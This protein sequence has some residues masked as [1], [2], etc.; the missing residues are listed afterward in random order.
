MTAL[1]RR[2]AL[3]TLALAACT[4]LVHAQKL[5]KSQTP[6]EIT[7]TTDLKDFLKQRDSLQLQRHDG[8]LTYKSDS[9]ERVTVPVRIRARGHFRRQSKTCEFPP[10][11]L[12]TRKGA[13]KGNLFGSAGRVKITT[14]C[15]P[16]NPEYEQYVLQE[17]F[18]Y[19]AYATLTD[20]GFRTRLSRI[21]YKD[22]AG[23]VPDVTTWAF[24]IENMETLAERIGTKVLAANG[25]L[26]D[27]LVPD[28]IGLVGV[29]E[30]FIGNTDWSVSRQHNIALVQ[31]TIGHIVP[32][33]YDFDWSGAVDARY[34]FPDGRFKMSSV[35]Q[36]LYRGECRT[37]QALAPVFARFTAKRAAIDSIYATLPQLSPDKVK[38][39]RSYFDDFWKLAANPRL[40]QREFRDGCQEKGN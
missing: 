20:T 28:A 8:Q 34:A 10:L 2:L 26:F 5:F 11:W 33:P 13:P 7:I 19:R 24:F 31:D 23:R 40:A 14:N 16:K 36:R 30:Y 6:I 37:E 21:T 1:S 39:M 4:S 22:S 17:L 25:A 32:V 35:T 12:E 38:K 9:G 18:L 3:V 29:F 15:R 27:D